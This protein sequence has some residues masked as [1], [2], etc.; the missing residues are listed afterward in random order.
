MAWDDPRRPTY[1]VVEVMPQS[2]YEVPKT[3]TPAGIRIR[4]DYLEDYASLKGCSIVA[5][6]YEERY[7][8]DDPEIQKLIGEQ[9]GA[10][11]ELPGRRIC[12][13]KVSHKRS[14]RANQLAQI[15]G[16]HLILKPSSRPIS[17][18]E[19][20]TLVWPDGRTLENS[21]HLERVYVADAVLQEWQAR[22][23][24]SVY[25]AT[26]DVAYGGWWSTTRS[27]RVG[28][29]FV[30]VELAKLYEGTP[31]YV[32]AHYHEHAVSVHEV[33]RDRR[34][35]GDRHIGQRA[36]ELLDAFFGMVASLVELSHKLGQPYEDEELIG[37]SERNVRYVGWWTDEHLKRLG[38][39]VPLDMSRDQFLERCMD[40][41]QLL[42]RL[43]PGPI[44]RTLLNLGLTGD[45]VQSIGQVG[46]LRYLGTLCQL[47]AIASHDGLSL[48]SDF[49]AVRERWDK[50]ARLN[51]MAPLFALIGIRNLRGHVQGQ[52]SSA[53]F[54]DALSAFG[55]SEAQTKRGWGLV[56]DRVYDVLI[57]SLSEVKKLID[58]A[59][60]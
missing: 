28:R 13:R 18:E 55:I 56:L 60:S 15:W 20:P 35:F 38:Y 41:H 43:K 4:R 44:K 51:P 19:K 1:D 9:E 8:R 40:L 6:Y 21:Q 14:D 30:A 42:E 22:P 23:E 37:I 58:A 39:V 3:Y 16:C 53:R 25:P 29:H 32:I 45:D 11:F 52:A 7:C 27:H 34:E 33:E 47:A 36:S 31:P 57:E 50:D 26:G 12:L 59:T 46:A 5:V 10:E 48:L 24:F 17:D 2:R 54:A 49:A